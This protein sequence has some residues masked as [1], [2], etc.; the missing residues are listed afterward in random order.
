MTFLCFMGNKKRK[1]RS[2]SPKSPQ[3]VY[4][5]LPRVNSVNMSLSGDITPS[6]I[7][8]NAIMNTLN[9]LGEK[10]DNNFKQLKEEME[11]L[12]Q[13]PTSTVSK[14]EISVEVSSLKIKCLRESFNKSLLLALATQQQEIDSLQA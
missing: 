12:K 3:T 10:M 4:T 1:K 5:K 8:L 13:V 2:S 9:S 6:L 11:S 14:L 7:I